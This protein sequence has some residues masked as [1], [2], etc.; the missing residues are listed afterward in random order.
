MP[1]ATKPSHQ[2]D[3]NLWKRKGQTPF[4]LFVVRFLPSWRCCRHWQV[5]SRP[6]LFISNLICK[7]LN[8]VPDECVGSPHG[9]LSL[10]IATGIGRH[11]Q[12]VAE[13]PL[14]GAEPVSTLEYVPDGIARSELGRNWPFTASTESADAVSDH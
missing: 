14:P 12:I 2:P 11:P 1:Q 10:A 13:S 8:D 6:K 3:A 5:T 9:N 4:A 7:A